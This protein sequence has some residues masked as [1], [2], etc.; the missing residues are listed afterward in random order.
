MTPV[1]IARATDGDRDAFRAFYERHV[2]AVLGYVAGRVGP[3]AA[4][5]LASETFVE[6]WNARSRF[7]PRMRSARPWLY[8]IAPHVC[9]NLTRSQRRYGAAAPRLPRPPDGADHA[10]DVG[11]AIL[12]Q[13]AP[14]V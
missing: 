3:A 14:P 12:Q 11:D 1:S 7:D 6:A 5:D 13:V 4:E 10:D 9:R 8:G 2:G